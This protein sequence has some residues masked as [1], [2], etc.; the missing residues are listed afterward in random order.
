MK[1]T[2]WIGAQD[3]MSQQSNMTGY[4]NDTEIAVCPNIYKT[5]GKKDEWSVQDCPPVKVTV[6]ILEIK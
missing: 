3:L 1:V 5:R 2:G 6:E 4:E